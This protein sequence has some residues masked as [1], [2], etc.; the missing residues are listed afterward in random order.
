[1]IPRRK[2]KSR[3]AVELTEEAVHLLRTSPIGILGQY[4]IGTLPFTLFLLYFWAD[5]SRSAFA[6]DHCVAASLALALL[7]IWMKSWHALFAQKIG[8]RIR[9]IPAPVFSFRRFA[10]IA[11]TQ[12][13][14]QATGLFILPLSLILAIPFGWAYAF[15]QN[16]SALGAGESA[17]RSLIRQTWSQMLFWPAQNHALLLMISA[18]GAVVFLNIAVTFLILPQMLNKFMGIETVFSMSGWKS[19]LNTTFLVIAGSI[20]YLCIDPL[21]KTVYALRCF[22]GTS[23]TSGEDLKADLRRFASHGKPILIFF[24]IMGSIAF[25]PP[26]GAASNGPSSREARIGVSPQ[27]L[28][29]AIGEVLGRKEFTWRMP[30]EGIKEKEPL[31]NGLIYSFIKWTGKTLGNVIKTVDRWMETLFDWLKKLFPDRERKKEGPS[32]ENWMNSIRIF[33]YVLLSFLI[34]ILILILLK[35]LKGRRKRRKAI[36]EAP[37]VTAL[38]DLQK[39]HVKADDLPPNR[40]LVLARQMMAEGS[41]QLALRAFYL[42]I[43]SHLADQGVLTIEG[44]KSNRDY[45]MELRRRAHEHGDLI[46]TFSVSIEVFD[47]SW[48]G[49]HEVTGEVLS[50]FIRH[51]ERI[52]AFVSK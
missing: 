52:M 19:A 51:Q 23:M 14:I 30:R 41:L 34:G 49:M 26:V 18:F 20:T 12:G 4:Y 3:T 40:W 42:A 22:Y 36:I 2:L 37:A 10:R 46:S 16:V 6:G 43:L 8:A 1:M 5:M 15:Y 25:F 17:A 44:Y 28:D 48:Y 38:P 31:K 7:F 29:Y 21:I 13:M 50:H 32:G 27:D 11:A 9:N 24:L 35:T 45:E 33:L 47:R 39:D